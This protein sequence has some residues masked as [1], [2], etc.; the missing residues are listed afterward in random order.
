[1]VFSGRLENFIFCR[2]EHLTILTE[3]YLR[4]LLEDTG[5]ADVSVCCPTRETTRP[6]L[7]SQCLQVEWESDFENPHTL[8]VEAVKR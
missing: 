8:L 7:F 3:S 5:F 6:E 2:G 1:M 4:E